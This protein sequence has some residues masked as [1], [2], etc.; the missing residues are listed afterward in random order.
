MTSGYTGG[1]RTISLLLTSAVIPWATV[2]VFQDRDVARF[3][4]CVAL[5]GA[6]AC[7]VVIILAIPFV[8]ETDVWERMTLLGGVAYGNIGPTIG[9]LAVMSGIYL[10]RENMRAAWIALAA[11]VIA[12]VH[13]GGRGMLASM[14]LT[15]LLG[16]LV[17]ASGWKRKLAVFGVVFVAA[18]IGLAGISK[19]RSDHFLRL[20]FHIE[21]PH[22]AVDDT[23]AERTELYRAAGRLF[24]DKPL[25]GVGTGRFGLETWLNQE[26]TTPHSTAFHVI[27]ELGLAGAVPFLALNLMLLFLAFRA[28]NATLSSVVAA[29]WI[30]FVLFDQISA[31][32][33]SS[34]RYYLFSAL[35]LAV[36]L[37]R[38]DRFG[39]PGAQLLGWPL[40]QVPQK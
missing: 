32:Y 21:S 1:S 24:L 7:L 5:F 23:L 10:M 9:L 34:L 20:A 35:L 40:R 29:V 12:I 4:Q 19:A 3:L 30:Y 37:K 17:I 26:L 13:M 16:S 31:N 38:T 18:V 25:T 14:L 22:R 2:R 15:F 27:S 11:S 28:R 33:L 39:L 36:S 8:S 6:A